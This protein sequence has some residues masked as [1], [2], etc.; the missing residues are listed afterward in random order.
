MIKQVPAIMSIVLCMQ[1]AGWSCSSPSEPDEV[2]LGRELTATEAQ[3]AASADHFGL[4]LFREVVRQQPDSNIFISP[5]SV[6]MALGMTA[7]GAAGATLDSMRA[8]LELADLTEA[9]SNAAY[10][11]LMA[12]LTQA[13]PEVTFDIANSIWSRL[14]LPVEADFLQRCRDFFNA[15]V[16]GADFSDPATVDLINGWVKENTNGK[17]EK[18]LD[19]IPAEAVMYL[20]NALYFKG[21]WQFEF[22]ST[23]TE[24]A[25]FYLADGSTTTSRLMS[26]RS[27]YRYLETDRFQLV[28]LPYGDDLFTMT[29]LLPK[30]GVAL[31]DLV[32]DLTPESWSG[33]I[34]AM[35]PDSGD[36]H[37]PKFKLAYKLTMNAVLKA[38]GMGVAFEPYGADFTR[39]VARENMG[40]ENLFISRVLHKTFVQVDEAGTEAAAVTAVEIALTSVGPEPTGFV[41]RINRPFIF[42]IRERTSGAL[43]FMGKIVAPVWEG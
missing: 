22:D 35:T 4:N 5:L 43:L 13:D 38:L 17:I 40:G 8:T 23:R 30:S 7:N 25:P 41:M 14:G 2:T 27:E 26:Q 33:W 11:S 29:V 10:Q 9:E 21:T 39:I 34:E 20:I 28:D 42:V 19:Q 37:L 36:I 31:D 3:L 16:K 32:A 12:L 15:E 1:L 18:I 6:S 24:N